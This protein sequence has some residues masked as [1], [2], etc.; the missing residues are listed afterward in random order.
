M[1]NIPDLEAFLAKGQY[2][3]ADLRR[4]IAVLRGPG[5]CP[6]DAEQTHASIRKN[7]LEE[8]YEAVDG[9]DKGDDALLCE[10]L[11]DVMLQIALHTQIAHERGAFGWDDVT[12]GICR[13]LIERH[14]HVFGGTEITGVDN[15][16]NNWDAIKRK[17]KGQT[18]AAGAM[19]DLPRALPALVRAQKMQSRAA[20]AGFDWLKTRR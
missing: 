13:K 9:I 14:P 11:G 20:K 5:G 10:E 16:L 6:W 17:T 12:D 1:T 15:V 3:T 4:I 19:A 8:A 18:S 2:D 7:F